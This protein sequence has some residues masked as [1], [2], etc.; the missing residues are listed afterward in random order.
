MKRSILRL[1]SVQQRIG[2][3][4]STIYSDV[5]R[6]LFTRPVKSGPRCAGWPDDEVDA[7]I[8]ARIAGAD[9]DAIRALI[10]R[11]HEARAARRYLPGGGK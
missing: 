7:V 1:P 3:S 9:D 10:T 2:K 8:N 11:L 5:A 4:R 6:G